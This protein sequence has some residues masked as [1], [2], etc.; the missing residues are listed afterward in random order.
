MTF[1]RAVLIFCGILCLVGILAIQFWVL[2]TKLFGWL[3][4]IALGLPALFFLE[5]LGEKV[6]RAPFFTKLSS[7]ARIAVGIPAVIVLCTLAFVLVGMVRHLA[8]ST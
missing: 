8:S 7:P 2:P 6:L 4:L 5:W 3:I 1:R